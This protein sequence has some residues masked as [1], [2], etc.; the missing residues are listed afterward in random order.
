[1]MNANVS[2]KYFEY[3]AMTYMYSYV[4]LTPLYILT[5]IERAIGKPQSQ[6]ETKHTTT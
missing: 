6:N 2:N 3:F 4:Q 5:D 1:M